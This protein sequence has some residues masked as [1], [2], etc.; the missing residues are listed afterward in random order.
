MVMASGEV[1]EMPEELYPTHGSQVSSWLRCGGYVV[2]H[3]QSECKDLLGGR[4]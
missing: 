1:C 4:T 3:I 2:L